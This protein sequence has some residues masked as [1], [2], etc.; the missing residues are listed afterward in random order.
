MSLLKK[1]GQGL[2]NVGKKISTVVDNTAKKLASSNNLLLSGVGSVVDAL[3]PDEQVEEMK[4]AAA[5]DGETKVAKVEETVQ[6]AAAAQGITDVVAINTATKIAAQKVSEETKT[7]LNDS[8]A[9]VKVSTW[10]KVKAFAKKYMYYLI[11]AG[12]V[13]VGLVVWLCTR[14]GGKKK[15]RR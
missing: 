7:T 15:F 12:V 9:S 5:R 3:I 8:E 11:A 1:I 4:A 10:E 14:K 2:K 6:A 13:L